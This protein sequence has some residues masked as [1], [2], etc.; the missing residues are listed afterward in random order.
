MALSLEREEGCSNATQQYLAR[1][2]W[3]CTG[4]PGGAEWTSRKQYSTITLE[5]WSNPA[6][7]TSLGFTERSRVRSTAASISWGKTALEGLCV[8]RNSDALWD[9]QE[10]A[11]Y[12]ATACDSS[13]AFHPSRAWVRDGAGAVTHWAWLPGV[14]HACHVTVLLHMHP[15]WRQARSPYTAAAVSDGVHWGWG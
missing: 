1:V 10:T 5:S 13:L 8:C 12:A 14:Q 11:T 6:M 4:M 7:K 15:F 2:C 9:Q 3:R